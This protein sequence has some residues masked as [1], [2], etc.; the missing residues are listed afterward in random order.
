MLPPITT[1][2]RGLIYG[3]HKTSICFEAEDAKSKGR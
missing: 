1:T 2:E 3:L